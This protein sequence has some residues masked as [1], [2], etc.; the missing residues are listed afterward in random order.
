LL[1]RFRGKEFTFVEIGV[2]NDGSLFMWRNFFGPQ[3]RIIG[4]DLNP[5]AKRWIDHG[6]E[7][8]IGSQ[9]NPLFWDEFFKSV[10]LV[11]IILDDGG[12]TDEQQIITTNC[13]IPFIKN[14]GLLMVEDVHASYLID[15]GNLSKYSYI[16]YSKKLIDETNARFP[17]IDDVVSPLNKYIYSI[18]FYESIVAFQINRD[19]C[20]ESEW[21]T[22]GGVS[23]EAEDYRYTD[24]AL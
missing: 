18:Q 21:A 15:F 8:F 9:S 20:F 7:I 24:S 13:C 17:G 4:I 19:K 12:H 22:N 5:L 10:G 1:S 11:D 6:F 23:L 2:L 3:A 14:S 16:N